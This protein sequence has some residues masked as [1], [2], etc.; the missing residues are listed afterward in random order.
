MSR[1]DVDHLLDRILI[2]LREEPIPEFIGPPP[3]LCPSQVVGRAPEPVI[4]S[5]GSIGWWTSPR[6][7]MAG[8]TLAVLAAVVAI[9]LIS[10]PAVSPSAAFGDVQEAVSAF[11]SLRYRCLDFHGEQDPYVTTI[12]SV[13]GVGSHAGGPAGSETITNWHDRRMLWLDHQA[14]RAILYQVYVEDERGE[15]DRFE[16]RM[17][18]LPRDAKELGSA[19]FNGKKVLRFAFSNLGEYVVL[20]D[21]DTKRPLRMELKLDKGLPGNRPFREVFTDFVFDAPVSESL[22]KLDIPP[23]YT[24]ERCEEPRDRKP[25]DTR[26]L[27][28]SPTKGVGSVRMGASK[29][30]VVAFFGS[31]DWIESRRSPGRSL[32][33]GKKPVRGEAEVALERLH[34]NS[35]GFEVMVSSVDG[36][37]EF[38]CL[39]VGT[40]A[41]M[42]LG[43]TD[44]GIQLGASID[45]VIRGHG[46]PEVKSQLRETGLRYLHKGWTFLFGDG[47]LKSFSAF[48]PMSD[49]IEVIDNGD[50]SFTQRPKEK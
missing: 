37:T 8:A 24:V 18:N 45:D 35:L 17:R 23:G 21:P 20:A 31:P 32:A 25:V 42:F 28:V 40:I 47:K 15:G 3:T 5:Q 11:K 39:P 41:R 30:E 12:V 27:V 34:Y 26:A 43:K 4:D 29:D 48:E 36:M 46:A 14:R 9:A 16:E 1:T 7:L 6:S 49:K 2:A 10:A 44:S 13:R 38:R 50:G 33:P 22:F 19:E